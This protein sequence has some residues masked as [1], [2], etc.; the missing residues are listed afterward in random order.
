[1]RVRYEKLFAWL[2]GAINA[3][4]APPRPDADDDD[5]DREQREVLLLDIF[6]FEDFEHNS[7]EQLMINYANEKLQASATRDF[8]FLFFF[9]LFFRRAR[10]AGGVTFALFGSLPFESGMTETTCARFP[11]PPPQHAF[12]RDV[13]QR[14]QG[15]YDDEGLPWP[16]LDFTD[17]AR[18][19]EL[20]EG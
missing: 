8:F 16:R 7:F 13:F 12:V 14:I 18:T 3:A 11:R 1:M 5:A 2:V 4:T 15:E 20:L 9:F 10:Q 19:L 17:N 6:G